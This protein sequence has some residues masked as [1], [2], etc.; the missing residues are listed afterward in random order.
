MW[1][2]SQSSALGHSDESASLAGLMRR[3]HAL[4]IQNAEALVEG[5]SGLSSNAVNVEL[6]GDTFRRPPL[7]VV[8][9]LRWQ[10]C[11][12][13]GVQRPRLSMLRLCSSCRVVYRHGED[14]AVICRSAPRVSSLCGWSRPGFLNLCVNLKS[15]SE[16]KG[17]LSGFSLC[18]WS[19]WD[20]PFPGKPKGSV[21]NGALVFL[22]IHL[23]VWSPL[24]LH[25]SA[26]GVTPLDEWLRFLV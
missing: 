18:L 17:G 19:R 3:C 23:S 10:A 11:W 26:L 14:A 4:V 1:S 9:R 6:Q 25:M 13:W 22:G 2:M 20:I 21:W 24:N 8:F 7:S 15:S 12:S 5:Y 16:K